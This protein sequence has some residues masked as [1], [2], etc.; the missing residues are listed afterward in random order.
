MTL[1]LLGLFVGGVVGFGWHG[2]LVIR[3]LESTKQQFTHQHRS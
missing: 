3:A 2:V 1:F